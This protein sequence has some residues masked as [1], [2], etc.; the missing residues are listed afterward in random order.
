M[1]VMSSDNATQALM[2][3]AWGPHARTWMAW[4]CRREIWRDGVAPARRAYAE[5]AR[6]IARF[7]P[8]VMAAC[9]RDAEEARA[10]CGASVE[11]WPVPLDD[12]WARDIA[13]VFVKK[14]AAVAGVD[15]DFNAW[16]GKY[17]PFAEDA[18]FAARLLERQG[19]RR[20]DGGM[21][22]E[23]GAIATD[24][25][26]TLLTTE[27]CLLNPNR[28]PHMT[29]DEIEA[30]LKE[31]LGVTRIVW[32]GQGLAGDE[33]DGH[34]DNIACFT[35]DGGV[36]LAMPKD[37]TDPS[38]EAMQENKATLHRAG[39]SITEVPLPR[40]REG[41]TC[42]YINFAVVNDALVV[43]GFRDPADLEALSI[44]GAKFPGRVPLQ[45]N[46]ATPILV[47]GGGIHC[48][49]YEEPA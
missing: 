26:G 18:G 42:S 7:E 41:L 34:V 22:L 24:G 5:V 40:Y 13:P 23:G 1:H 43:P 15:W 38:Y 27:D 21:V 25:A 46:D 30:R 12:S 20:I 39:L 37:K 31:K 3:P 44:I 29:R 32:L 19:L 16:G 28:N 9:P 33:T 6:A 8:V 11:I 10:L 48:I 14:G 47:G 49:T 2:P 35:P 36:L 45:I 17:R 4:P